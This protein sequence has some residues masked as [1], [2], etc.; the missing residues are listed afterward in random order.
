MRALIALAALLLLAG[1]GAARAQCAN[2]LSPPAQID[3]GNALEL[4]QAGM[5]AMRGDRMDEA[6]H[7]LRSSFAR[8][9]DAPAEAAATL[10]P[11]V[12]ARLVEVA[13]QNKQLVLGMYRMKVLRER[14]ATR[15]THPGWIDQVMKMA[16]LATLEQQNKVA[17]TD[18]AGACRSFGV[19][20]RSAARISFDTGS[21]A[22]DDTARA[23]IA[24]IAKNLLNNGASRVI[25]R[26]HTDARGSDEYNDALSLRRA[27]AV[28]ALL[29]A[30]EPALAAKLVAEGAG[31]R[32]PLYPGDDEDSYRLNRRV[33]FAPA[34]AP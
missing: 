6:D 33:E 1:T 3:P 21:A 10:E 15:P 11:M 8:L 31:K 17:G 9:S 25:V 30:A 14:L 16:D 13:V 22:I 26:G 12:I 32:E 5:A 23:S 28:I 18:E 27:N 29:T 4:Y 24:Q 7:L 2:A 19:A 20:V 34:K